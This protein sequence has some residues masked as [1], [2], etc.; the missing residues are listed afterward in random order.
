MCLEK[1]VLA[2]FLS[3]LQELCG[4]EHRA[5]ELFAGSPFAVGV[6]VKVFRCHRRDIAPR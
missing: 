1:G 3:R 2:A 6:D 4:V 5:P